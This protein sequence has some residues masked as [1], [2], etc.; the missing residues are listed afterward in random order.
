MRFALRYPVT[1]GAAARQLLMEL[2][3]KRG[4]TIADVARAS[5]IHYCTL[6]RVE[7]VGNGMHLD[8]FIAWAGALGYRVTLEKE[9]DDGTNDSRLA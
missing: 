3:E 7:S 6:H 4:L 5:G 8:T 1:S 2:R 9:N